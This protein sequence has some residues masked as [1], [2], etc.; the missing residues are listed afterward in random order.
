MKNYQAPSLYSVT[1]NQ[2]KASTD[3]DVEPL[4]ET[5]LAGVIGMYSQWRPEKTLTLGE[6]DLL[7]GFISEHLDES[8][9]PEDVFAFVCGDLTKFLGGMVNYTGYPPAH[10]GQNPTGQAPNPNGGFVPP[11]LNPYNNPYSPLVLPFAN[12]KR[13][14]QRSK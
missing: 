3:K 7:C 5:A 8:K 14:H 4:L 12:R 10:Y 1:L 11:H 9:K 6:L 13:A 2:I